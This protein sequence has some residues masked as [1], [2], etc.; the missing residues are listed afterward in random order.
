MTV[1]FIVLISDLVLPRRPLYACFVS[2]VKLPSQHIT[3]TVVVA[4][5]SFF[6]VYDVSQ[7]FASLLSL[8]RGT[9]L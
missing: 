7:T 5:T 9:D 1:D 6:M 4:V 2:S 8:I 3:V